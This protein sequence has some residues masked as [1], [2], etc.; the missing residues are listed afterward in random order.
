MPK[1]YIN[2]Y[3]IIDFSFNL[4]VGPRTDR[5]NSMLL[6]GKKYGEFINSPSELAKKLRHKYDITKKQ[7]ET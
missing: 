6:Y 2:E 1:I 5:S 3:A 7:Q 4:Y